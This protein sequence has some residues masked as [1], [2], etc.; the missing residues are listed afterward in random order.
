MFINGLQRI[1]EVKMRRYFDDH[2]PN[3]KWNIGDN[4]GNKFE[5]FVADVIKMQLHDLHPQVKT[6]QTSRTADGGKDIIVTSEINDLIILGQ[7]FVSFPQK[8]MPSSVSSPRRISRS[9]STRSAVTI[10]LSWRQL[11]RRRSPTSPS[12][13]VCASA[14]RG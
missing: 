9:S 7:R 4:L 12:S 5:D 11:P 13:R 2:T 14:Y 1:S 6:I 8:T 3:I 10:M